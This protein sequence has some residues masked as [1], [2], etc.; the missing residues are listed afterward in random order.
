MLLLLWQ[1][2]VKS[3]AGGDHQTK[4]TEKSAPGKDE[5]EGHATK[6]SGGKYQCG[7]C[8]LNGYCMYAWHACDFCKRATAPINL[9]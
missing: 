7:F 8:P 4:M 5:D 1:E 6:A 2:M 9:P 3:E